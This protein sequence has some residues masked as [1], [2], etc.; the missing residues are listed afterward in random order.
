MH[1]YGIEV[2]RLSIN[3]K[4][5]LFAACRRRDIRR[6]DFGTNINCGPEERPHLRF[7]STLLKT[8]FE[9]L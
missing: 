6:S 9:K 5:G 4:N 1:K 8:A 7:T 3:L 2:P